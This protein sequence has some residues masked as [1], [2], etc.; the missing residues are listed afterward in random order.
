MVQGF[1]EAWG[2][3][4]ERKAVPGGGM[5]VLKKQTKGGGGEMTTGI[6]DISMW[7]EKYSCENSVE[8]DYFADHGS[9]GGS[10]LGD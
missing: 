3:G 6:P 7:R 8:P 10:S 9:V 4:V 1:R 5:E 2:L